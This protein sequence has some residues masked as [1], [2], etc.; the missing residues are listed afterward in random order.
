MFDK[1]F[2]HIIGEEGGYTN[3]PRDPGGE[4]KY[5]ITK[6]DYPDLDIANL[7]VDQAKHIYRDNYWDAIKADYLP[8]SIATLVFDSAVNQGVMRATKL[9]QR[10]L[11]VQVDGVIGPRTIAAAQNIDPIDFAV[12]FGAERA[13]HYAALSNFDVFGRGWMRRL[14]RTTL[15]V[16]KQRKLS[17]LLPPLL[18]LPLA[19]L[20]V[21]WLVR[22][23]AGS[24]AETIRRR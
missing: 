15:K 6:R 4:T 7:T 12:K 17:R 3:H 5:G 18:A 16:E 23:L 24:L 22:Y 13:L 19:G 10:A 21:A 11:E 1:A 9:M 8:E 14:L 2:E 20:L